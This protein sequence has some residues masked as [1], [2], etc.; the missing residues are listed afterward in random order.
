MNDRC[1]GSNKVIVP[2]DVYNVQKDI[3]LAMGCDKITESNNNVI[4]KEDAIKYNFEWE[5][6]AKALG[7]DKVPS[8]FSAYSL[9][10]LSCVCKLLKD[11]WKTP[12]WKSFW[13]YIFIKEITIFHVHLR[14]ITFNFNRKIILGQP[15]KTPLKIFALIGMSYMFNYFL[16]R[17]YIENNYNV[18]HVNYVKRLFSDLII[19]YKRIIKNNKWL[20]PIGKKNALLKL[21]HITL[22]VG[23]QKNVIN[24][25]LL[26]YS[27]TDAWY[28]LTLFSKWK[29]DKLIGLVSNNVKPVDYNFDSSA[30][31][32]RANKL[33]GKQCYI[34]N[35]F[36][37]PTLNEVY[38]PLAYIQKPFLNLDN[39]GI[40]YIMAYIGSTLTHEMSHSLDANGS[41]FN[42]NG[43]LEDIF[44]KKDSV[45][46]SKIA[47]DIIRQYHISAKKDGYNF[48]ASISI[49]EDMA[50]ISGLAITIGYLRD[51]Y[52]KNN[53]DIPV[54]ITS[55]EKF[56]AYYAIANKSFIYKNAINAQL[57][58]NPH[59]MN[60]YRVNV[61]LSRLELFRNIY[62][63]KKN[64]GMWWH[65]LSKIWS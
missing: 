6:F 61:P 39:I 13:I 30:I 36:Y 16:S 24:D 63:V 29:T 28:N 11:N 7:Y 3:I 19:I 58:T 18:D 27:E 42:Y 26:D 64:D 37:T 9:N 51:Y 45:I 4:K 17:K 56:F 65:N 57:I 50:D 22:D 55:L 48:D 60:K 54:M 25:P 14:D 31:D 33:T 53:T 35:S 32:W 52:L 46:Y 8:T 5:L 21:E 12:K 23:I 44:S 40:E 43:I 20:S 1:F 2:M 41:K 38:I 10:Y 49:G 59:P 62:K 15:N 34:V 47:N